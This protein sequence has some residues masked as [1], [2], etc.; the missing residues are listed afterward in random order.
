MSTIINNYIANNLFGKFLGMEF[1]ITQ[2]GIVEYKLTPKK[3]LEAIP[4]MTHGGAIAGFMDGILGVA[5]LSGVEAEGKLVSTVEFK[6]N[7][8][9]PTK[10]NETL[11]GIGTLLHKGK[12]TLVCEGKIYNDQNELKATALGTFKAYSPQFKS[13]I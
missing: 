12:S 6:I 9:S 11:H 2:P 3:A 10:T 5:A 7:Y 1:T 8:L 4:G 13:R